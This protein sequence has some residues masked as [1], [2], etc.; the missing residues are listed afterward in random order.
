MLNLSDLK[1]TKYNFNRESRRKIEYEPIQSF[2]T[3]V[4]ARE[5]EEQGLAETEPMPTVE[6]GVGML[7]K[8]RTLTM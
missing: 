6:A 4:S 7:K 1:G 3:E 5:P 8:Q 2:T